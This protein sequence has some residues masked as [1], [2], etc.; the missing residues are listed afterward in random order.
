MQFDSNNNVIKLCAEG[1]E[2]E[3]KGLTEQ[4]SKLFPEAWNKATN[5]FEKFTAAHY[6]G[7]ATKAKK[8]L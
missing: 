3:T 2:M 5:D 7:S 4:A 8:K 1:M 6:V